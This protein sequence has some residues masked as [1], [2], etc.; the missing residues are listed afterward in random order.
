MIYQQYLWLV[1]CTKICAGYTQL[2]FILYCNNYNNDSRAD[3]VEIS[4]AV[5]GDDGAIWVDVSL[6]AT[7][8]LRSCARCGPCL[9]D[10]DACKYTYHIFVCSHLM[11]GCEF[12]RVK[13]ILRQC[14]GCATT[15]RNSTDYAVHP[16]GTEC[17]ILSISAVS[18]SFH[19]IHVITKHF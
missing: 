2:L 18:R 14:V 11:M 4:V 1:N 10:C 17:F 9:I 7:P 12:E 16:Y 13:G 15:C 3:G 8:A 5:E 19:L 6:D